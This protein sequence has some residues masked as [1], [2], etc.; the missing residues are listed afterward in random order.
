M[1]TWVTCLYKALR[2]KPDNLPRRSGTPPRKRCRD[3]DWAYPE[4]FKDPPKSLISLQPRNEQA[5]S[6][7]FGARFPAELRII[8]YETVLGDPS[9]L[10]HLILFNDETGRVGHRRCEDQAHAGPTWQHR[11]FGTYLT[12]G[13]SGRAVETFFYSNDKLLALLLSCHRMYGFEHASDLW[14]TVV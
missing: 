13:I 4:T 11:C 5:Q 8:V 1:P 12:M 14:L 10:L 2:H 3:K 7:L 9:R 6:P